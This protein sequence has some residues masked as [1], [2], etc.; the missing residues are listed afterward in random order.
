MRYA[1]VDKLRK[2][3]AEVHLRVD[4]EHA[5]ATPLTEWGVNA[6]QALLGMAFPHMFPFGNT[7]FVESRRPIKWE[8]D[9]FAEWLGRLPWMTYAVACTT[10]CICSSGGRRSI[11]SEGIPRARFQNDPVF[12]LYPRRG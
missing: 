12:V 9:D 3:D 7:C 6:Q 1:E 2:R 5:R 8:E 10:P 11:S 4:N